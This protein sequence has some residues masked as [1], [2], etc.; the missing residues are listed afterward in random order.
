[1]MSIAGMIALELQHADETRRRE[2]GAQ[3]M[4][5]VAGSEP[6]AENLAYQILRA[7]AER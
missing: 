5:D 4:A 2:Y 1:M 6:S 3:R 7:Y